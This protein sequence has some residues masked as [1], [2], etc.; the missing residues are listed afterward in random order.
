MPW[1][2][3]DAP[4]ALVPKG[5]W[6][7]PPRPP[8]RRRT[9]GTHRSVWPDRSRPASARRLLRSLGRG[10]FGC[11][12]G[13]GQDEVERDVMGLRMDR[14]Q[15]CRLIPDADGERTRRHCGQRP[16]EISAA[17]SEAIATSITS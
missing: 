11:N 13:L 1:A 2:L 4:T 14:G 16:V 5:P 15:P 7:A 10:P 9:G 6:P 12:T 8:P 3:P 17:I